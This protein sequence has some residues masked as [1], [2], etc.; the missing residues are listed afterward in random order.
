MRVPITRHNPRLYTN[1]DDGGQVRQERPT[2][3]EDLDPAIEHLLQHGAPVLNALALD[4]IPVSIADAQA[5]VIDSGKF[6][7]INNLAQ[8]GS[9]LALPQDWD[10]FSNNIEAKTMHT[11]YYTNSFLG[12]CVFSMKLPPLLA[13]IFLGVLVGNAGNHI[14]FVRVTHANRIIAE[15]PGAMLP[16]EENGIFLYPDPFIIVGD[17]IINVEFYTRFFEA[18]PCTALPLAYVLGEML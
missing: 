12:H 10:T 8:I 13:F 17:M 18:T 7:E 15:I 3:F 11:G 1:E 5:Y 4:R 16:V 6:P 9:R 2:V 14:E